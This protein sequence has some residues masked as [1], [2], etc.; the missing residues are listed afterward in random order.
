M[1][2]SLADMALTIDDDEP[3]RHALHKVLDRE[4][5]AVATFLPAGARSSVPESGAIWNR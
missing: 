5:I 2:D 1:W 3:V 4:L